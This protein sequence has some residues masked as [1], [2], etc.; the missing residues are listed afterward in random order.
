MD[1]LLMMSGMNVKN[2]EMVQDAHIMDLAPTVLYLMGLPVPKDLDG[3]VLENILKD[4]LLSS[5]PVAV[6]DD[7]SDSSATSD[8]Y[9]ANEEEQ[10]KGYLKSL[11]YF[12]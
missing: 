8:S 12:E 4:G 9:S 5:N 7:T 3:K 2:G 1:G 10:L 11:G 6:S